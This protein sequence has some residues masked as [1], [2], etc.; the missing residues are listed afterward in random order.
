MYYIYVGYDNTE[1]EAYQACK[2]SIE[3]NA[4]VPVK[5]IPLKQQDL[6]NAGL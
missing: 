2:Q 5:I 4:T 3:D 1:K 6:R